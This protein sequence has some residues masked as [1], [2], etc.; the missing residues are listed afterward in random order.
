MEWLISSKDPWEY[1]NSF[2][3]LPKYRELT[4]NFKQGINIEDIHT[5]AFLGCGAFPISCILASKIFN[6]KI[7]AID[8]DPE[9]VEIAKKCIDVLE[10]RNIDVVLGDETYLSNLNMDLV[11]IAALAEPKRKIFKYIKYI[12]D[13]GKKFLTSCR[14]Y[15]GLKAVLYR[16]VSK[17]DIEGFIVLKE[18]RPKRFANNTLLFLDIKRP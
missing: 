11:L 16:P 5:V 2:P 9:K 10:I 14:T 13:N 12:L 7:V 1:L 18:I 8:K 15:T 6:I 17:H 3:L 4:T